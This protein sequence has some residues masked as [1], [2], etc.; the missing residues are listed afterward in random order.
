MSRSIAAPTL[1]PMIGA[2][3]RLLLL[4]EVE[5]LLSAQQIVHLFETLQADSQA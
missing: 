5:L 2:K 4:G 1:A 3:L